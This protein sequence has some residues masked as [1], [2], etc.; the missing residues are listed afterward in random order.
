MSK[1]LDCENRQLVL[2]QNICNLLCDLNPS[3]H[4]E[5]TPKIEFWI[6]YVLD[7]QYATTTDLADRIL[8]IVWDARGSQSDISR[9]LKE[10][11]DAPHRSELART[12]VDELC[13]AVLRWFPVASSENVWSNWRE[14][15]VS[16]S[17][18]PG[19]IHAVSFVGHLIQCGL[20]NHKLVR[21]H[22]FKPLT[23]HYYNESNFR[24]QAVR[25]HA[26]YELF[27]SAGDTLLQG[28]L[29]PEEVQDC[30]KKL[31]I[32]V[33]IGEIGDMSQFDVEKLKVWWIHASVPI[34]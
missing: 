2:G 20:L 26:I 23:A 17:G 30:F 3:T 7:E 31:E 5:I 4:D 1:K 9:F 14:A 32:R 19:F 33:S 24:K 28:L 11:R 8:P 18:G 29:E 25:A 27:A 21:R 12:F 10:F 13:F 15:L 22:I 16:K 34:F 6:D